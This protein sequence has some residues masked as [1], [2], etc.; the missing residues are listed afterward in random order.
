MRA[1]L[2]VTL[3][4]AATPAA[5]QEDDRGGRAA[6]FQRATDSHERVPGGTLLVSAYA[7]IWVLLL[8]F[9]ALQF[10]RTKR[11]EAEVDRLT[12]ALRDAGKDGG[13]GGA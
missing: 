11:I 8:G 6:T 5:A 2:V 3:L 10:R 1:L 12:K 4:G 7:V 9:V 13:S